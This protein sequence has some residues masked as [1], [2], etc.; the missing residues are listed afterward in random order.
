MGDRADGLPVALVGAL[1]WRYR[2]LIESRDS[3][4]SQKSL[5]AGLADLAEADS[6]FK[7]ANKNPRAT[8]EFLI[9]R[10]TST[11]R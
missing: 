4:F 6:H 7:S 11:T 9:V 8:M 2:T 5:L 3:R 10:L 1:A